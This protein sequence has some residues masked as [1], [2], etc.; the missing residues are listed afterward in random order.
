VV[1][2]GKK[3]RHDC[4]GS[5]VRKSAVNQDAVD[6]LSWNAEKSQSSAQCAYLCA[7]TRILL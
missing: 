2:L 6:A 1:G 7:K 4:T 5:C 3:I